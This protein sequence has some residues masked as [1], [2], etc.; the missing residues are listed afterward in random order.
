MFLK[1]FYTEISLLALVMLLECGLQAPISQT[2]EQELS[3]CPGYQR[4]SP[5]QRNMSGCETGTSIEEVD[6]ITAF[7]FNKT[8]I[9]DW[10]SC[11]LPQL[12]E[13]K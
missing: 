4:G 3:S 12:P 7:G 9:P 8:S 1:S 10:S 13:A 11:G 2:E 5:G 6:H